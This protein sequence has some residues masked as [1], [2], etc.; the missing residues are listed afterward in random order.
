[1]ASVFGGIL[2]SYV[3]E[4]EKRGCLIY[5]DVRGEDSS[6]PSGRTLAVTSDYRGAAGTRRTRDEPDVS[7]RSRILQWHVALSR[8]YE[9][10]RDIKSPGYR[11]FSQSR[12]TLDERNAIEL[13]FTLAHKYTHARPYVEKFA[14]R[15]PRHIAAET[16]SRK[17]CKRVDGW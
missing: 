1:M 4:E 8:A 17:R 3:A 9:I 7:R 6:N 13:T 14:A 10:V 12:H 5:R 2:E 15:P 11:S 16:G